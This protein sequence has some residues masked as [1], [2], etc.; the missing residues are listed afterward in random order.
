MASINVLMDF[1]V[2]NEIRFSKNCSV[3]KM[4]ELFIDMGEGYPIKF[5]WLIPLEKHTYQVSDLDLR[6][7]FISFLIWIEGI[8]SGQLQKHAWDSIWLIIVILDG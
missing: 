5:L 2:L 7:S 3:V 4:Q 1:Y 6:N 8:L